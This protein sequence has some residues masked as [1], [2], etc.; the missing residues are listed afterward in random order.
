MMFEG[1]G[2]RIREKARQVRLLALDVDGVLTEGGLLYGPEGESLKSFHVRDGLGIRLLEQEGYKVAIVSAR[3][4]EAL[5]QRLRDLGIEHAVQGATNKLVA[6]TE[7]VAR[8]GVEPAQC[9]FVGDDVVDLPAMRAAGL[10]LSVADAHPMV[11]RESLYVTKARG[12]RGAVR[13]VAEL[14][15]HAAGRLEA[16]SERLLR[17]KAGHF[18]VIIPARWASSR[19]PGKPLRDIAGKPM[20]LHVCDNARLSGARSVLVATDDP[21]IE[22]VARNAG[23]DVILTSA[24]HRSG[25][26]RIAEV[27]RNRRHGHQ[28]ILV[29]VQGDEPLLAPDLIRGA[30]NSLEAHPCAGM[31]TLAAPIESIEDLMNP[32]IV[33]VVSNRAGY[34]QYFSR[35]PLPFVRGMNEPAAA[36]LPSSARPLRHIGIYAY[37]PTSLLEMADHPPVMHEE[38]ESL[39]QLRALWLG[40]PIF[41]EVVEQTPPHGVDTEADLAR[42]GALLERQARRDAVSHDEA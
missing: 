11:Q 32:N 19:L 41:V 42:V 14:L 34:A 36:V 27:I 20:L 22:R 40:I 16:A 21:R 30:A 39:E 12:G 1:L 35:A 26:D 10:P 17:Q 8:L 2:D 9:A 28:D 13:E 33:K 24:D 18:D 6:L 7:L 31:A 25:T 4:S 5:R 38:C 37:R 3:A 15:L 29:N 23:V